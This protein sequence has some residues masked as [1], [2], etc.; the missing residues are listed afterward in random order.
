MVEISYLADSQKYI[1]IGAL[2]LSDGIEDIIRIFSWYISVDTPT[3]A[4]HS[5]KTKDIH[6]DHLFA[7]SFLDINHHAF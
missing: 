3:D 4:H 5:H 2:H 1:C 7:Q 6:H